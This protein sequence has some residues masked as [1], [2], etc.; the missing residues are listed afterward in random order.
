MATSIG[1]V[2][3]RSTQQVSTGAVLFPRMPSTDESTDSEGEASA[4][5]DPEN[6]AGPI[7]AHLVPDEVD[8]A[9]CIKEGVAERLHQELEVRLQEERRRHVVA[10]LVEVETTNEN[11]GT[12]NIFG[13]KPPRTCWL[14]TVAFASRL[15]GHHRRQ[16]HVVAEVLSGNN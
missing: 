1:D 12:T 7:V 9:A 16:R 4:T 10:E 11:D 6:D 8:L 2:R 15:C 3:A 13:I 14:I 5:Q